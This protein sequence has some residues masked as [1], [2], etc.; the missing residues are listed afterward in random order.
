[1]DRGRRG[2][3]DQSYIW[4]RSVHLSLDTE[5]LNKQPHILYKLILQ[6]YE[7]TIM[8]ESDWKLF[9]NFKK[10]DK[11]EVISPRNILSEATLGKR[12]SNCRFRETLCVTKIKWRVIFSWYQPWPST[13]ERERKREETESQRDRQNGIQRQREK[14]KN[15][16][17]LPKGFGGYLNCFISKSILNT[18]KILVALCVNTGPHE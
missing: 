2:R 14:T 10:M 3:R 11:N 17:T 16:N 18:K 7:K 8:T 5:G 12:S 4:N 13:H 9:L 15:T 1:M 6:C